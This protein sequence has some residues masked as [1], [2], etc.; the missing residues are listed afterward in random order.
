VTIV[1]LTYVL[2]TPARNEDAFIEATILSVV[3]QTIRPQ[4]W[5]IVSDGST[6][7]TDAIIQRY[8]SEHA[9]IEFVRMPE[10]RDRQFAAKARC[11]AAGYEKLQ[12]V[13]FDLIGNL[14]ADI[15]LPPDYYEF[16]VGRFAERPRLGVAGT[17]FVEDATQPGSHTYSHGAANLTHVSG[18]CQMFRRQ[19]FEDVGGYVQ[20]K[21]GAIDWIAVT[22]ARM[23]GWETR[24]FLERVCIHHRKIGTGNHGALAAKFHY[25]RKAYYVGGHPLWESLRGIFQLKE[26]PFIFGGLWFIAGYW[27]GCLTRIHRPV[28]R[29]L[30]AFHRAEQMSRLRGIWRRGSKS[31]P[32][33]AAAT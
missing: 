27:W 7:G 32:T 9:W 6:D 13:A 8:A 3:R 18:A 25:G 12:P 28:S 17:P 23:K 21:G 11:F 19:C 30:I 24:T 26:A 29:E 4:K 22:T 16:L 33:G 2:V 14:D 5:I 31:R 10:H 1:N 20:I 15:T